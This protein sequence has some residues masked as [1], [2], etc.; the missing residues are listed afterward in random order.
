[1]QRDV[2]EHDVKNNCI[3]KLSI[4]VQYHISRLIHDVSTKHECLDQ[5]EIREADLGFI[6]DFLDGIQGGALPQQR[7][8][9]EYHRWEHYRVL[10]V[11]ERGALLAS[12]LLDLPWS[13]TASWPNENIAYAL[14]FADQKLAR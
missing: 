6:L 8:G 7:A 11:A 9:F 1:L 12:E 5:I 3:S 13:I 10:L 2:L 14:I 4:T